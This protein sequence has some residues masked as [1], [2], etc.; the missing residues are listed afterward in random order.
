MA[1]TGGIIESAAG[2][3]KAEETRIN[4]TVIAQVIENYDQ[5]NQGR[6]RIRLPW[7]PGLDPWARVALMDLGAYF[8]PQVGDEVLVTFNRGDVREPY[9][10]GRLWNDK[11]KPPR[12]NITDPVNTRVI[13][14]PSGHEVSFDE[15]NKTV[16]VKS[17]DG[18]SVKISPEGIDIEVG[19]N[20]V[21]MSKSGELVLKALTKIT[22]DAPLIEIKGTNINVGESAALIKI[23]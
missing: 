17:S 12:Q 8:I 9:I 20:K 2:S 23:G 1:N 19:S 18:H 14:S 7:M 5:T 21:T 10:I 3:D 16:L 11:N 13:K 6:V 4:G 22:L 15:L